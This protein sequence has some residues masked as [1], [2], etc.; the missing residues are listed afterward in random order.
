MV[1]REGYC[2]L[3]YHLPP[4]QDPMNNES[5]LNLFQ[6]TIINVLGNDYGIFICEGRNDLGI[7]RANVTLYGELTDLFTGIPC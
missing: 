5:C 6:L 1:I 4:T 7:S 3:R 2:F